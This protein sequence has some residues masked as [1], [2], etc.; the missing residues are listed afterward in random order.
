MIILLICSSNCNKF[1]SFLIKCY[2]TYS[3]KNEFI[4]LTLQA[5]FFPLW[6]QFQILF[7]GSIYIKKLEQQILA[8][9]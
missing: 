8:R 9:L 4:L 2:A 3:Y 5:F 7:T 6:V 1:S